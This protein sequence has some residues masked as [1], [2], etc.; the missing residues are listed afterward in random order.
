M[1]LRVLVGTGEAR[2]RDAK[3]P[4][5]AVKMRQPGEPEAPITDRLSEQAPSFLPQRFL[6][7]R[8]QLHSRVSALWQWVSPIE[9]G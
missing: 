2:G 1:F 5:A 6:T 9:F 8:Q 7:P 4:E 3:F